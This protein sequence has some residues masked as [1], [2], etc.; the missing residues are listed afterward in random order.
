MAATTERTLEGKG[1]PAFYAAL[2]ARLSS[3]TQAVRVLA[4][5]PAPSTGGNNASVRV[6][7]VD[8]SA[9][10]R[11]LIASLLRGIAD[12]IIECS[13]GEDAV[14][15]YFEVHPD[16]VL[17]DVRMTGMDGIAATKEIVRGDP[18]ARVI[19]VSEYAEAEMREAVVDAGAVG[20]V[21]KENLLGI[22]RLFATA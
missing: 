8:D 15:S 21:H 5:L 10:V 9:Q 14:G 16:W 3:S 6:L 22:R 18:A 1:M 7:I 20:Y 17:M 11:R 12:E 2:R 19:I 13:N 4:Y